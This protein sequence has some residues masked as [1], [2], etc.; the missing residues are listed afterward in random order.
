MPLQRDVDSSSRGS[1]HLRQQQKLGDG[2]TAS[3]MLDEMLVPGIGSVHLRRLRRRDQSD[4]L[5]RL[6]PDSLFNNLPRGLAFYA[7][8]RPQSRPLA[9]PNSHLR[10]EVGKLVEEGGAGKKDNLCGRGN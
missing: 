9:V 8:P 6:V 4:G 2:G 5:E 7:R 1:L 10:A 3:T